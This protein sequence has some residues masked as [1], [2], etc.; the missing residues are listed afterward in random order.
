MDRD[1]MP[2]LIYTFTAT[3]QGYDTASHDEPAANTE[4]MA[5]H[6]ENAQVLPPPTAKTT[7]TRLRDSSYIPRPPN[8]FILFRSS[9]IQTQKLADAAAG[10]IGLTS[11]TNHA[12]LS[13]IIAG[14]WRALP[15]HEKEEWEEKARRAQEEHRQR[16]PDWR[17]RPGGFRGGPNADGKSIARKKRPPGR[18]KVRKKRGDIQGSSSYL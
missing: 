8:A 14:H 7:H 3:N 9:F 5:H 15:Q 6:D 16:Y 13:R 17:F 12:A 18:A 2:D 11:T 1:D 4:R 10:R